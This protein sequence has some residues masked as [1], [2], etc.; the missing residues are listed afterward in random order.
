MKIFLYKSLFIFFLVLILFKLTIGKLI[1]NYEKKFDELLSKEYVN[2]VKIE[3]REEIRAGIKK[4]NIAL[5]TVTRNTLFIIAV[6]FFQRIEIMSNIVNSLISFLNSSVLL[7]LVFV[8]FSFIIP[9]FFKSPILFRNV[10]SESP[11]SFAT[12]S[13]F[14]ELVTMSG[15]DFTNERIFFSWGVS[16]ITL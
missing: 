15:L 8:L 1:T 10:F 13:L 2:K 9:Y 14:W 3:I 12:F 16:F 6:R 4:D 7:K 5:V 11:Y